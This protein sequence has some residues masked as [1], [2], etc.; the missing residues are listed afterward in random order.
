MDEWLE[1]NSQSYS[2]FGNKV[3]LSIIRLK[4][5]SILILVNCMFRFKYIVLN[6]IKYSNIFVI[7]DDEN[8][9]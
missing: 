9:Y 5:F 2:K 6:N 3:A 7:Y 1:Y 4:L 8:C